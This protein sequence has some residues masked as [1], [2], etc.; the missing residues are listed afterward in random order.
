MQV[1]AL[2]SGNTFL[3]QKPPLE[4]QGKDPGRGLACGM[5]TQDVAVILSSQF[6][7][8]GSQLDRGRGAHSCAAASDVQGNASHPCFLQHGNRSEDFCFS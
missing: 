8:L 1:Q 6:P 2:V 7:L 4:R 5:E 3:E